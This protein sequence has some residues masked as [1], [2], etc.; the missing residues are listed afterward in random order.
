MPKPLAA[1]AYGTECAISPF[2]EQATASGGISP[3]GK[4]IPTQR[5]PNA[6]TGRRLSTA[7]SVSLIVTRTT[8]G[9]TGPKIAGLKVHSAAGPA[10]AVQR[11]RL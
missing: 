1:P 11:A 3:G 9:F 7:P 6:G 2:R 8:S 4:T 10:N 5:R